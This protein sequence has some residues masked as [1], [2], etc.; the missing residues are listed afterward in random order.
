MV[1]AKAGPVRG[2]DV[3]GKE[4]R[5]IPV[6][7]AWATNVGSVLLD[8]VVQCT[9]ASSAGLCF[10]CSSLASMLIC[11]NRS[12]DSPLPVCMSRTADSMSTI[13]SFTPRARH[14]TRPY[15]CG[16]TPPPTGWQAASSPGM[17][18]R[19]LED[20]PDVRVPV[21]FDSRVEDRIVE[22]EAFDDGSPLVERAQRDRHFHALRRQDLFVPVEEPH[23]MKVGGATSDRQ[24]LPLGRHRQPVPRPQIGEDLRAE[25]HGV[26][27]RRPRRAPG[28]LRAPSRPMNRLRDLEGAPRSWLRGSRRT[29]FCVASFAYRLTA[30]TSGS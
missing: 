13:R 10:G 6:S 2:V 8:D 21:G 23:A 19:P 26:R 12:P 5:S 3:G 18:P 22:D 1:H 9:I 20:L 30:A 11:P 24:I 25:Y 17:G 27:T 15:P 14:H 28:S 29:M 7:A 16:R 4:S